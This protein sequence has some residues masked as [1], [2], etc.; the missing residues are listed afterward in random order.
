MQLL[1]MRNND[2]GFATYETM[3]GGKLLEM[4]NPSEV[5][6]LYF[7]IS[8]VAMFS[9]LQLEVMSCSRRLCDR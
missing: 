5:F 8:A 7:V 2:G 1:S 9:I 4:L 6:G 3:R